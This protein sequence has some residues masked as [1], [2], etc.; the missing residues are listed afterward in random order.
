MNL[1]CFQQTPLFPLMITNSG[2]G[3]FR[4]LLHIHLKLHDLVDLDQVP[5][6][7]L[8]FK[9][10]RHNCSNLPSQSSHWHPLHL[11]YHLLCYLH[12]NPCSSRLKDCTQFKIWG[13][14][15]CLQEKGCNFSSSPWW[16]SVF[17]WH[18]QTPQRTSKGRTWSRSWEHH[19]T[20]LNTRLPW[21]SFWGFFPPL[22]SLLYTCLHRDYPAFIPACFI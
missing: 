10:N 4:E 14:Y 20:E 21:F 13:Y 15:H 16:H 11:P 7:S 3:K 9:L 18:P 12:Y 5:S 6:P 1:T 8:L 22:D 2:L 17:C 19:S